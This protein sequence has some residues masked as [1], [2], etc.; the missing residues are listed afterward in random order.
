MS[1]NTKEANIELNEDEEENLYEVE[2]ILDKKKFGSKWKYKI[3]WVGY[4][5][6]ECTWEPADNLTSVDDIMEEFESKWEQQA[7]NAKNPAKRTQNGARVG[8]SDSTNNQAKPAKTRTEK[9]PN[10]TAPTS[11]PKLNKKRRIED[12]VPGKIDTATMKQNNSPEDAIIIGDDEN[13]VPKTYGSFEVND[14]PKK[15]LTARLINSTEVHCLVEWQTRKGGSKPC[16][17]FVH[18]LILREKCPNLLLD[19]YESRLKFPGQNIQKK[20]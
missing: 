6:D 11:D 10:E 9:R 5:E 12:D 17:S 20:I 7:K 2:S 19:F 14:Y 13:L 18:N 1:V 3:K 4:S 8:L 16:D 15:L